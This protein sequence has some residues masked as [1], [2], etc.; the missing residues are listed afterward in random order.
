M[1]DFEKFAVDW[2]IN[3]LLWTNGHVITGG[4][5]NVFGRLKKIATIQNPSEFRKKQISRK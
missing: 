3:N 1:I 5:G 2:A 4:G